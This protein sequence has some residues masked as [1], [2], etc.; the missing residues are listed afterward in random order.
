MAGFNYTGYHENG[1]L[2]D[3][4]GFDKDG[5]SEPE[6]E[7]IYDSEGFSTTTPFY[8]QDTEL[9]Y[10]M[11]GFNY[12]GYHENGTLYDD[13]GY[14]SA[15]FDNTGWNAANVYNQAYDPTYNVSPS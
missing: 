14:N 1:T 2:Y 12:T 5:N 4:E 3:S 15:G 10:N 11:A 9:E 6:E 13:E 8:A 7:V